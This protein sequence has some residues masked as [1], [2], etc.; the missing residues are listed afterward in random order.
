MSESAGGPDAQLR[1]IAR[2]HA[3]NAVAPIGSDK[4][5]SDPIVAQEMLRAEEIIFY[6]LKEAAESHPSPAGPDALAELEGLR[7]V[8]WPTQSEHERIVGIVIPADKFKYLHEGVDWLRSLLRSRPAQGDCGHTFDGKAIRPCP[9][10]D[11]AM[12]QQEGK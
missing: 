10:C 11:A 9:I 4:L 12:S 7:L 5:T 6:A 8:N 3:C 1:K 2:K